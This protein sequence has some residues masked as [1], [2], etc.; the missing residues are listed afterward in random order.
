MRS[1]IIEIYC[2]L[3]TIILSLCTTTTNIFVNAEDTEIEYW[4][5]Y[6]IYPKRCIKYNNYDQIMYSMYEQSSNYCTD[7]AMG[8]YVASVPNF[9][10][11]YLDQMADNAQGKLVVV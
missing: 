8:T 1:R 10:N 2:V 5:D 4:T 7:T 9:V 3:L 11:A 6:A